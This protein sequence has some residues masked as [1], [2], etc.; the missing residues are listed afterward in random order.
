MKLSVLMPVFNE[1]NTLNK[2]VSRVFSQPVTGVDTIELIIV[3]DGSTDGSTTIIRD[4]VVKHPESIRAIYHPRNLGKGAAVRKAIEAASGDLAIIQDADLEYS[5]SD[6]S[7]LLEPIL[8]GHADVIYGTRFQLPRARRALYFRQA[9]GNRLITWLSNLCTDLHLSDM[10]VGYK[11]FRLEILKTIP[12]RSKR[13]GFEAEITAK[14]AKRKLRVDEVPIC[15]EGRT[16]EEGKKITWKDGV[17]AI[18][19]ILK[20]L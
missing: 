8:S 2:I 14:I 3:D 9:I 17:V 15:Y 1:K 7:S 5:P 6:Y 4:L 12:L 19:I 16:Y 11:A 10:E 20:K 13:F 18:W